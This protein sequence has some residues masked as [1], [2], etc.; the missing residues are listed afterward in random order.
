[1]YRTEVI[2]LDFQMLGSRSDSGDSGG[3]SSGGG[4]PAPSG[5][6]GFDP[7]AEDDD[8]PF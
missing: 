1:M 7:G 3:D 8:I 6:S 2:C 5:D 4:R